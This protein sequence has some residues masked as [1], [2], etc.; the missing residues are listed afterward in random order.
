MVSVAD[1]LKQRGEVVN[2][3]CC[4]KWAIGLWNPLECTI[5]KCSDGSHII[6]DHSVQSVIFRGTYNE[7]RSFLLQ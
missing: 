2:G 1:R 7:C 6:L 5:E 4:P 3:F